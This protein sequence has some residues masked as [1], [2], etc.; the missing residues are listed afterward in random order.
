MNP[1]QLW[2]RSSPRRIYDP[3]EEKEIDR[4]RNAVPDI[5]VDFLGRDQADNFFDMGMENEHAL[6][7]DALIESIMD[8]DRTRIEYIRRLVIED[9]RLDVLMKILGYRA[10]DHQMAINEFFKG[11]KFGLV[12]APRGSG[13]ST[14]ANICYVIMRALQNRD[15]RVL[16]ASRTVQQSQSFLSE[17]KANLL[18]PELIEIFGELRGD[19]WDETQADIVGRT[20]H[21]KEHTFTIAGA[22]GAVVSKHF[23]LIIADDLVEL[24]NSRTETQRDNLIRFFYT[25]LLPTLRPEGEFRVLGT[26]YHP[27]DLYGYLIENDPKFKESHLVIPAVFDKKTG[28]PVDLL[29]D[30]DGK[31][32]APKNATCYDPIGFPMKEIIERRASMPLADFECQ[33][34]NRTKFMS[35]SFF[36]STWFQY[37]DSD[38]ITMVKRYDLAVWMGVDLASSLKDEADEFSI[39][40]IGVIRQIFEIYVLY[41]YA[42]RLTFEEQ[43]KRLVEVNDMFNP[44]RVFVE[45]NAY[46]AVLES[47]VATEW[48][49]IPTR[50][51]WTTKDKIT[52]ARAMQLYY[53]RKQVY[54][55]KGRMSAL[56]GQLTGFPDLKL[57]DRVD[58]LYFAIN[59]A[60]QGGARK[61][62]PRDKEP[63]LF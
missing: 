55:R 54:H 57:K 48:P 20:K 25:S 3:W 28:E 47:T 43:Q 21:T 33:Y 45:A 19:K 13:K 29:Q 1:N 8:L 62:R 15:I 36:K 34:Q 32:Y 50:P 27:E 17:I 11:R 60:L 63:G 30:E 2:T 9:S 18:K 7:R 41:E 4:G 38:P 59:G 26:R 31:F 5:P 46:Q 44:V 58:A 35:G 52:R 12:L 22:D 56:E 37:Y 53:E 40:V 16:I 42:A 39:V 10:P 14:S 49:D 51:I 23:D 6:R 61:R 24:R